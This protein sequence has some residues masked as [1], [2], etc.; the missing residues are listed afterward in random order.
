[1]LNFAPIRGG[2]EADGVVSVTGTIEIGLYPGNPSSLD[3]LLNAALWKRSQT[4]RLEIANDSGTLIDHPFGYLF[5]LRVPNL[6]PDGRLLTVEVGDYLALANKREVPGD[7][8][9]ITLGTAVDLSVVCQ[10]YLEA[11]GIPT[12]NIALGG[13]WGYEVAL[14]IPKDNV[15]ALAMAGRIAYASDFRVLYQNHD[16]VINAHQVTVTAGTPALS[17]NVA[18]IPNDWFERA[19]EPATAPEIVKVVGTGETVSTVSTPITDTPINTADREVFTSTSYDL[20]E[21]TIGID[22]GNLSGADTVDPLRHAS[23]TE[24]RREEQPGNVAFQTGGSS[25]KVITSDKIERYY[26]QCL[27]DNDDGVFPYRLIEK[28]TTIERA[29]GITDGDATTTPETYRI[30][31]EV[32]TFDSD[33]LIS[34]YSRETYAR[35]K[36]FAPN[37]SGTLQ[38]R[39]IEDFEEAWTKQGNAYRYDSVTRAAKITRDRSA[40]VNNVTNKW[41]LITVD[42]DSKPAQN[43]GDNT[44]PAPDLWEGPYTITE[45]NYEGQ[46]TYTPPGGS[47]TI[48]PEEVIELPESLGISNAVCASMAAKWAKIYGGKEIQNEPHSTHY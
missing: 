31:A 48:P 46:A 1:V 23:R 32:W 18:T 45:N 44:P 2:L 22:S 7:E 13:P 4:V 37:D 35:Q 17:F 36:E 20:T 12:G 15:N 8:S 34:K 9:G 14:T 38:W 16:G 28:W 42:S 41:Q 25:T 11:A 29:A 5:I 39:L 3:P 40:D 47:S 33:D 6:S 10:S 21:D 26:Y 43:Q 30:I 24:R 27:P 19:F